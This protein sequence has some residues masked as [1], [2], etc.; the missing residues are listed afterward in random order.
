MSIWSSVSA[1]IEVF[2]FA[3]KNNSVPFMSIPLNTASSSKDTVIVS[4]DNAVA[5]PLPPVIFNVSVNKFIDVDVEL[6]STKVS[7]VAGAANDTPPEPSVVNTWPFEP[8]VPGN[9]NAKLAATEFGDL[10]ETK[11]A[12]LF[13]PS[14]NLSVPPTVA[15]LPI[16]NVSIAEL[17]STVIAELAVSVPSTWSNLSTNY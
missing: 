10:R 1:V 12:P 13:V 7:V 16:F 9:V 14:L 5:I 8:S 11:C 2:L 3:S 6:S 15:E 4:P 17:L